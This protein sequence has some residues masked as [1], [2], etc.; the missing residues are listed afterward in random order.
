MTKAWKRVPILRLPNAYP[1]LDT[2]N[3]SSRTDVARGHWGS[4]AI[5]KELSLW[6]QE[7]RVQTR[8]VL[9]KM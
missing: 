5:G 9:D 3:Y 1:L 8:A 6:S 4:M 2:F 7:V